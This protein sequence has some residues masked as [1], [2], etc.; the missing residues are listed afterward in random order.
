MAQDNVISHY[1]DCH[2]LSMNLAGGECS[3]VNLSSIS[4]HRAQPLRWTYSAT[5][6]AISIMTKCMALDLRVKGIRVNAV[7]PGWVWSPE[8]S[9]VLKNYIQLRFTIPN[10]N[11]EQTY[12][13]KL[14]WTTLRKSSVPP[15]CCLGI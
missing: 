12:C 11:A 1:I 13:L 14:S 6:G 2:F 10:N 4:A 9:L 3:I 8:V 5:K 15:L 7:A